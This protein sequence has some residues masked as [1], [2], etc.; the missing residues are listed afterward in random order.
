MSAESLCFES[1]SQ[2]QSYCVL[3]VYRT[4]TV[5]V[6]GGISGAQSDCACECTVSAESLCLRVHHE[7]RDS[8]VVEPSPLNH[9]DSWFTCLVAGCEECRKIVK[10]R[11]LPSR[12]KYQWRIGARIVPQVTHINAP[13]I[14]INHQKCNLVLLFRA[15]QCDSTP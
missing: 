2:M 11:K 14:H 15:S 6:L 8:K 5:T 4:W 12:N 9:F 13:L 10:R 3:R 1:A 7:R